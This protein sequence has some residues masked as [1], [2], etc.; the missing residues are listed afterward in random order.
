MVAIPSMSSD[1]MLAQAQASPTPYLPPSGAEK[2]LKYLR[3][4]TLAS[5]AT[6]AIIGAALPFWILPGVA[7]MAVGLPTAMVEKRLQLKNAKQELF[8]HLSTVLQVV[9]NRLLWDVDV[10]TGRA[11]LVD[12]CFNSLKTAMVEQIAKLATQKLAEVQAE[13]N[14][15]ADE[16]KLDDQSARP[17]P[18]KSAS[19]CPTG[20][21][22]ATR[23][24]KFWPS[25]TNWTE[26]MPPHPR[27]RH[28]CGVSLGGTTMASA[29]FIGIDFGTCNS[30]V[31]WFN[32]RTGEA[33]TFLNAEG[34]DKTPSVVY[35]GP[36]EILVGKHAED[37][38]EDPKT[39]NH[40]LTA[41]KR[42]LAK[43]RVW[44]LGER[45][46]RSVM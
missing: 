45:K 11:S 25:C 38:L 36:N 24:R 17:R 46:V 6:H 40:V 4:V 16:A 23:S 41:V 5:A 20:M 27:P 15:L 34:E 39:R 33:D 28:E 35:F 2:W 14:R 31:A 42:E 12:E 3:N 9:R 7:L 44:V 30:S 13:N 8:R 1:S 26:L 19:N 21:R 18:S 10:A 22:S 37:R 29:P 43:P 32:P